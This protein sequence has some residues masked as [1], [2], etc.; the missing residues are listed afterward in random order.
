MLRGTDGGFTLRYE[1]DE[2]VVSGQKGERTVRG[3]RV[4]LLSD[5]LEAR[6]DGH[7][8]LCDVADTGAFMRVVEAVRTAPDPRGVGGDHVRWR[9]AGGEHHP[10]VHDVAAWCE[11]VARAAHVHRARRALDDPVLTGADG[12]RAQGVGATFD[13]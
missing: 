2:A 10:V 5:L 9:G 11:R 12:A 3:E 6:H 7:R 8:L 13:A 1:R 4:E